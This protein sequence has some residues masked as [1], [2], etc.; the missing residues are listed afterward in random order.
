MGSHYSG[1]FNAKNFASDALGI[2]S[3]G[4]FN[5]DNMRVNVPFTSAATRDIGKGYGNFFSG[6]QYRG[7]INSGLDSPEAR[8]AGG[9]I[10]VGTGAAVGGALGGG[11][12]GGAGGAAEGTGSA[13]SQGAISPYYF[14]FDAD[15]L[16]AAGTGE[17]GQF[18][19]GI[20]AAGFQGA[21][22]AGGLAALLPSQSTLQG[23]SLGGGIAQMLGQFGGASPLAMPQMGAQPAMVQGGGSP[24]MN[25]A[26]AG[27]SQND[28]HLG[29]AP[30]FEARQ[31]G[32]REA[33]GLATMPL[34][35]EYY[36]QK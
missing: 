34:V 32:S 33:P 17:F 7:D 16:A 27:A 31:R 8:L 9:V 12:G 35:S 30:R 6:G 29:L 21:G 4:T 18:A 3:G 10:G 23:A 36:Q 26:L 20:P 14:G 5:L 25:P 13:A 2:I 22:A 11:F 28:P 15:T 1:D 24:A 19:G